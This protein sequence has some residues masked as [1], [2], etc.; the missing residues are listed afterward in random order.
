MMHEAGDSGLEQRQGLGRC[1]AS[2]AAAAAAA[3]PA[4]AEALEDEPGALCGAA[5][6]GEVVGVCGGCEV[7]QKG[8]IGIEQA[9]I[10]G[11]RVQ[12]SGFRVQVY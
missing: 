10:S 7:L 2:A 11:L 5:T 4:A 1:V 9:S 6:A 12:G 3:A 8:R